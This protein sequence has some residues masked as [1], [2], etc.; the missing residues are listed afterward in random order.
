MAEKSLPLGSPEAALDPAEAARLSAW[1]LLHSRL[2]GG[3]RYV[4]YRQAERDSEVLA[5]RLLERIPH[6]ELKAWSFLG[7]PRGG[8]IVLG[9][10]AYVLDLDG[11]ALWPEAGDGPLC[12]VDDC[13]LT[14]VRFAE[15]LSRTGERKVVFAHLYSHPNL[16]RA[17]RRQEPRVLECLAAVDLQEAPEADLHE[18]ESFLSWRRRWA[19]R[20]GGG[21]YWLGRC[22]LVSF[23]WSEPDRPFWNPATGA[24]EDGWRWLPP[25]LCLKNRSLVAPLSGL[26]GGGPS[27]AERCWRVPEGVVFGE[28]DGLLWLIQKDGDEVFR[29]DGASALIWRC[30]AGWGSEALALRCLEATFDEN[31]RELEGDLRAMIERFSAAR[32]LEL[33]P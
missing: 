32:L 15:A 24:V 27:W 23:S 31:S 12:I 20:L 2:Q 30:L 28:F 33:S 19:E 3:M 25:H 1:S 7:I 18:E 9:M 29:L 5:G 22:E 4:D 14:G 16:R 6:S 8:L 26:P 10:L 21:R 13:A 17:V 11:D